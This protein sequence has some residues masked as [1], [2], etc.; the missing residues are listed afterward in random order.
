MMALYLAPPGELVHQD[1]R[2]MSGVIAHVSSLRSAS[3][4]RAAGFFIH[5]AWARKL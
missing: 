5:T 1:R 4:H 3:A 2:A